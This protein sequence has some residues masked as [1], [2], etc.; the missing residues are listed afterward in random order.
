VADPVGENAVLMIGILFPLGF[1]YI[2]FTNITNLRS[3][4][5]VDEALELTA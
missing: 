5:L 1:K 3:Y 4:G 2:F